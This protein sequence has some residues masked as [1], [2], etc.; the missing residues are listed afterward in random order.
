[1]PPAGMPLVELDCRS[2][3]ADSGGRLVFFFPWCQMF[4]QR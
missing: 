2:G 4:D 3:N 1:M